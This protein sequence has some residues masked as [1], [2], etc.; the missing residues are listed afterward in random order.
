MGR[1][2]SGR[3]G[4]LE[5]RRVRT[6]KKGHPTPTS[7]LASGHREKVEAGSTRTALVA[8]GPGSVKH[9]SYRGP[10]AGAQHGGWI[11]ST[12]KFR[13][14]VVICSG[15]GSGLRPVL[16]TFADLLEGLL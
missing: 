2:D 5:P 15:H 7:P 6:K 1:T 9:N 14:L 12:C 16:R 8:L 3:A 11:Q 10:D 4:L 13:H